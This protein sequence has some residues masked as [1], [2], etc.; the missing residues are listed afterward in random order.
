MQA[1]ILQR[2]VAGHPILGS[3]AAAWKHADGQNARV[4]LEQLE[5]AAAE[6]LFGGKGASKISAWAAFA[7][8]A[9]WG[10]G[11]SPQDTTWA[12]RQDCPETAR[13]AALSAA[14]NQGST[15]GALECWSCGGRGHRKAECKRLGKGAEQ[16]RA[17]DKG[18][19]RQGEDA[20]RE[21]MDKIER[22]L[23]CISGQLAAK[24][25]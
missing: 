24:N 5:A 2:A 21:R 25:V 14:H 23:E 1:D 8:A 3:V 6:G 19:G 7:P 13:D 4:L 15:K 9:R 17:K 11:E 20:L 10:R 18:R 16:D 22:M 12:L